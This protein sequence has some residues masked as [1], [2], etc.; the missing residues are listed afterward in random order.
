MNKHNDQLDALTYSFLLMPTVSENYR[1]KI[2]SANIDVEPKTYKTL[3]PI[4]KT[5]KNKS[6]TSFIVYLLKTGQRNKVKL[7]GRNKQIHR[8]LY[9]ISR[10][11]F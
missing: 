9:K 3:I 5:R 6:L 4:K 10:V 1:P 7:K 8:W 11:P 2:T